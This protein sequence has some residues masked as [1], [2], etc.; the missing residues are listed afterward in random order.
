MHDL[1]SAWKSCRVDEV[2]DVQL[3]R[4]RSPGQVF[5]THIRPYL[6]VAN[7]LN[8]RIDY[9]DVLVMNFSPS[10]FDTYSLR[11]GDILINEGQS[12][13]LVGR[14][15][16]YD[17]PQ[18]MCFQNTL[19]RFRPRSVLPKFAQAV[20]KYWLDV[21][22]FRQI[23]RQTTSIA[24]LGADRFCAMSF[25]LAPLG[26]QRRIVDILDMLDE[27]INSEEARVAKLHSQRQG[28]LRQLIPQDLDDSTGHG[29]IRLIETG[30]LLSG[31]T[32]PTDDHR[33][34]GG[35]I[36]WISAASL[37]KFHIIDSER[38]ITQ[39]GA[40]L[41][42]RLIPAGAVVFVVRGMSLKSEFRIGVAQRQV[43][44]GQDCKAIVPTARIDGT[45]LAL[46]IKAR[47]HQILGM[48]DE[49][50]HGTGRL[51]TDLISQLKIAI[52]PM[53]E[54]ERV[55]SIIET[56]TQAADQARAKLEKLRLLKQGLMDDLLTGR[57][58][59]PAGDGPRG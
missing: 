26:E 12:L 14:C 13:E 41:G 21:G 5:G 44:F 43:A 46:A 55:V 24:H 53:W 58:R 30:R 50:G 51:P 39:M 10:E 34:W 9:S 42:S 37:K 54:Q 2:G 4:Q 22:K 20:F 36:P 33:Y 57:V 18:G 19:I 25:P 23:A 59:V 35:E 49:A 31:G 3:G 38:R 8:G 16:I 52:P 11:H 48:V 28:L 32:P 56:C 1:P 29:T 6:R 15:A 17:G 45:Y 7:V 27:G 47:T 40:R